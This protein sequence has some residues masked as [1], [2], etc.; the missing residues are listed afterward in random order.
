MPIN[1]DGFENMI[2]GSGSLNLTESW[3]VSGCEV[4]NKI[5]T[6]HIYVSVRD[7]AMIP[8]P[9]CGGKTSRYGYEDNERIWQHGNASFIYPCIVHWSPSKG[10]S[11][12]K[13][14]GGVLGSFQG[15]PAG[16]RA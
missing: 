5:M 2:A 6:M 16:D 13:V 7:E 14:R 4:D 12:S 3:Y 11:A 10:G 1:V 9:K 8:C 15:V